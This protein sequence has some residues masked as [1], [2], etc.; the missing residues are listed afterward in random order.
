M[1]SMG[2]GDCETFNFM[3]GLDIATECVGVHGGG[4][5][6]DILVDQFKFVVAVWTKYRVLYHFVVSFD[7][8]QSEKETKMVITSTYDALQNWLPNILS[9]SHETPLLLC[10]AVKTHLS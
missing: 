1:G 8:V 3:E 4:L 5:C 2:N 9:H 6:A 7:I 10:S